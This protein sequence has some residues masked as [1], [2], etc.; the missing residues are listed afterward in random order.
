MALRKKIKEQVAIRSK[1]RCEYCLSKQE[2]SFLRFHVDHIIAIKHGGS[3]ELT[4]LAFACPHCNQNKGSDLATYL[5]GIGV[6]EVF[7]PRLHNWIDHFVIEG[8]LIFGLTQIGR[9]TEKLLKFNDVERVIIRRI[10]L[11]AGSFP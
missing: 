4:N 10:L 9:A 8:G 2:D 1:G 6:Q 3:N 11:E 5:E 7:N